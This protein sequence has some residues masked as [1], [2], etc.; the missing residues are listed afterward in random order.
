ML[1]LASFFKCP[2]KLQN[3]GFLAKLYVKDFIIIEVEV[4]IEVE[5]FLI[6]T[7]ASAFTLTFAFTIEG[8]EYFH[9]IITF[10]EII[11]GLAHPDSYSE[12]RAC[13]KKMF[14]KLLGV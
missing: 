1:V 11:G 4:E 6:L 14:L 12:A 10:T 9:I 8:F 7:F 13:A 5:R 3:S 2:A